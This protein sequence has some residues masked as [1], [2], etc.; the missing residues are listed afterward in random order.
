MEKK[1]CCGPRRFYVSSPC[2]PSPKKE[3][4]V[5]P[6]KEEGFKRSITCGTGVMKSPKDEVKDNVAVKEEVP[7]KVNVGCFGGG[8]GSN[9]KQ[10]T[11]PR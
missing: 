5:S 10:S 9:Y 1:S 7:V 11:I 2:I 4:M 6:K 8:S 3:P